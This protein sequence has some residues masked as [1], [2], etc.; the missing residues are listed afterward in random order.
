[1]GESWCIEVG[2]GNGLKA[3][4]AACLARQGLQ[5][6]KAD[7]ALNINTAKGN[8]VGRGRKGHMNLGNAWSDG[9]ALIRGGAHRAIARVDDNAV[10]GE[11]CIRTN[12]GTVCHAL[13]GT[14]VPYAK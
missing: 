5:P 11:R 8:C 4:G 10:T 2:R 1:M 7:L 14:S 3:K 13:G 6:L 12:L 9:Y